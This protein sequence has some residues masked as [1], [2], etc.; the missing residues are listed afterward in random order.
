M[1]Q[2]TNTV[3][4]EFIIVISHTHQSASLNT[5]VAQCLN[6]MN[7]QLASLDSSAM[8]RPTALVKCKTAIAI[9]LWV[10]DRDIRDNVQSTGHFHKANPFRMMQ[11]DPSALHSV[12]V[13]FAITSRNILP[14]IHYR[15]KVWGQ[16]DFLMFLKVSYAHRG[17][18]YLIKNI[19]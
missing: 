2:V 8:F 18:I 12:W 7:H 16:N 14:Y 17:C 6:M 1:S 9:P 4:L 15:S 3:N 11:E 19:V 5:L 10:S 13:Y